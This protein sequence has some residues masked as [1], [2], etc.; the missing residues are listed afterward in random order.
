M[1]ADTSIAKIIYK[2]LSENVVEIEQ[3][4]IDTIV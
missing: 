4:G 1:V 2:D 3:L